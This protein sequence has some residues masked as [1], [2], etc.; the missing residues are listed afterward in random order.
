MGT[1]GPDIDPFEGY[2]LRPGG[3]IIEEEHAEVQHVPP[4]RFDTARLPI[5]PET[6]NLEEPL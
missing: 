3:L 6:V 4:L 5:A 1:P 2:R